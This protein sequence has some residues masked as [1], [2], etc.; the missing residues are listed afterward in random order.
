MQAV[1]RSGTGPE[2]ALQCNLRRL[3]LRFSSHPRNLPGT[4]DI[5]FRR[6]R[7]AVFVHGCFWHRHKGCRLA[8]MPRSN[9]AYWEAKFA[10]NQE[11]DRRKVLELKKLGWRPIIVW[12]CEIEADACRVAQRIQ[13]F[14]RNAYRGRGAHAQPRSHPAHS[15]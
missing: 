10:A 14:L 6:R 8:T 12:Q 2:L 11:R 3:R 13:A 4:P 15:S 7:V 1:R 5:V 9:V